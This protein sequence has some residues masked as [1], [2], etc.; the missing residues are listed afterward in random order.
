MKDTKIR[1]ARKASGLSLSALSRETQL[2]VTVLGQV[3]TAKLVASS[4]VRSVL[5]G[6][7]GLDENTA[8]QSNG[9]AA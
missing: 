2:N 6:F 4:R 9:L 3:E 8:F 7:L 1:K 5:C